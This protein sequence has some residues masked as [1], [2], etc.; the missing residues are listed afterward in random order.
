MPIEIIGLPTNV[1]Q[2]TGEGS[3]VKVARTETTSAQDE[4]GK[5]SASDTVTLTELAQQL[6]N[7]EKL[8]AAQPVVD[9]Q[10]TEAVR[11]ALR[12]G[13]YEVNA[14]R[15]AEKFSRFEAQLNR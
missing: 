5:S 14:E 12:D 3:Q 8:I 9:T 15:V 6:H 11:N 13:H 4:T 10:R 1:T 7:A 2:S